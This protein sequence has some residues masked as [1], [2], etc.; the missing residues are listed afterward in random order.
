MTQLRTI[1]TTVLAFVVVFG[2]I[3]AVPGAATA[4]GTPTSNAVESASVAQTNAPDCAFPITVTDATGEE[5]TIDERPERVTTTNPS[6][7]QIMWEI[8]GKSQVVGTSQFAHYLDG[9]EERENVSSTDFGVNVE[10]VV[11]TEP[12]L[13]LAPNSTQE[14]TIEALR[15]TGITVYHF[16]RETDIED[17][18][19]VTTTVGQLTGNC[20]GAAEA[21]A[22]VDANVESAADATV[23]ADRPRVLYPLGGGYVV[24]GGTFIDSM[25]DASGAQNL[26]ADEFDGYQVMSDEVVLDLDPEVLLVTE[27]SAYLLNE[28]PYASTAAGESETTVAV[29][30]N[31]LNQPAPG[32]VVYTVSNLTAQLHPDAYGEADYVTRSEVRAQLDEA[33]S[34]AETPDEPTETDTETQTESAATESA[35]TESPTDETTD[36]EIPGFGVVVAIVALGAGVLVARRDR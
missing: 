11:G 30:V 4:H 20:E 34:D 36:N 7:A 10:L 25:I 17:V 2:A 5:V 35:T 14:A 8:G 18:K 32:S 13:V 27:T 33:D 29:D 23:D 26:A 21:N 22:W 3:G 9:A 6:A 19:D 1:L 15:N 24:G 12:D 16:P 31:Y 28:E